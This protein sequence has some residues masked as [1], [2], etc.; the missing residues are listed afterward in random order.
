MMAATAQSGATHCLRRAR[1]RATAVRNAA[2]KRT[3][4]H[5]A[6]R[7]MHWRNHPISRDG[8]VLF[9]DTASPAD[10]NLI[11]RIRF[12]GTE[13]QIGLVM[14]QTGAA[15]TD[16]LYLHQFAGADRDVR[17]Q[18]PGVPAD[19]ACRGGTPRRAAMSAEFTAGC[20]AAGCSPPGGR[21]RRRL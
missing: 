18:S 10:D 21:S 3:S 17:R 12:T 4:Q 6:R 9:N 8:H 14:R 1:P 15:D 20:Q 19:A 7:R 11:N 16:L 13:M 5:S 2:V